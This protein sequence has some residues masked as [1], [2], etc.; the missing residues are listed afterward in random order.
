MSCHLIHDWQLQGKELNPRPL[1]YEPSELHLLYPARIK[2]T[3]PCD[4]SLISI[5]LV[6]GGMK[7]ASNKT[8][9]IYF[10]LKFYHVFKVFCVHVLAIKKE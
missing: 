4:D 8:L 1:G 9:L 3:E 5:P 2:P 10:I 6:G 7:N